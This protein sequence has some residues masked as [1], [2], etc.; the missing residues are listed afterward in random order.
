[1]LATGL[2]SAIYGIIV[3]FN[4]FIFTNG[5]VPFIF[6]FF[7]FM[8]VGFLVLVPYL[9]KR[10]LISVRTPIKVNF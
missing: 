5:A 2:F 9:F 4:T 8:V 6:I 3:W 10:F 1:M 7:F